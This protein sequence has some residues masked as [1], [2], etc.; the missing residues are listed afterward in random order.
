MPQRK[1]RDY[2]PWVL[3][4]A[5][6]WILLQGNRFTSRYYTLDDLTVSSTAESVG[7]WE[8]FEKPPSYILKNANMIAREI[9][10]PLVEYLGYIPG[11]NSWYRIPELN[12]LVG[13]VPDSYHLDALAL[14]LDASDPLEIAQAVLEL[15][16]PFTE[17][18]LEYGSPSNPS[19]I[20]LAYT[21]ENEREL[22]F[23]NGSS[24][25][26]LSE[27]YVLGL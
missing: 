20:H 21:G 25:T 19:Y 4:G 23:Y 27:S 8:Q 5:G 15:G 12:D 2:L 14:D 3:A 7:M 13:G 22:L 11:I 16:L 17:L 1:K 18:I 9:L 26:P 6:A 24:Y 10:D